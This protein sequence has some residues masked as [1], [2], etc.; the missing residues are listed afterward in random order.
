MATTVYRNGPRNRTGAAK[1]RA[2]MHVHMAVVFATGAFG[3]VLVV[4]RLALAWAVDFS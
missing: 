4:A 3:V 1:R 2:R